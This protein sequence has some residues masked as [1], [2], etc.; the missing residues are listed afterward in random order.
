MTPVDKGKFCG[1]CQK[2]VVDFS[3]MSDRQVAE[4]FKK[5]STG[6]V[7]GR[8]MADQLDRG[9]EIPKK[10]I[11]WLKYFFRFVIPAFLVSIKASAEKRQGK[12]NV[13][14]VTKDTTKRASSQQIVALGM[15]GQVVCSKPLMGDTTVQT[16]AVI[17]EPFKVGQTKTGSNIY[18]GLTGYI[19][20]PVIIRDL[21]S[22][23]A[24]AKT[25]DLSIPAETI[26]LSKEL[27]CRVGGLVINYDEPKQIEGL[28]TDEKGDAVPF[29]SIENGKPGQGVSA[30]E[31]GFFR[32]NKK[33]LNN[34]TGFVVSSAGFESR[35]VI[36]G[37]EK[38]LSG[39]LNVQLKSNGLL[40]EVVLTSFGQ[41]RQGYVIGYSTV[42]GQAILVT[43]K[44]ATNT[45]NVIKLPSEE[46]SLLVY[47]NP[48]SPGATLNISFK[49]PE[50]GYYQL[51]LLNQSGQTVQQKE[52]R[53]DAGAKMVNINILSVAAGSYYL[54]LTDKKSGKRFTEK[55][56][57]TIIF[58]S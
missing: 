25:K 46:N 33:W 37:E 32:I 10:R 27:I 9:I 7:C 26:N 22:P 24:I 48:V 20:G 53:M 28:V 50:E 19:P 47:P 6:S 5:P 21:Q 56:Y 34:K 3:N 17:P 12:I 4:F 55:N 14:T 39:K 52:I 36:K 49:N 8:F 45:N 16:E 31:N 2:Q 23:F 58:E 29:A 42:K 43:D 30:D 15:T 54:V 11:P 51:Q 44:K 1:S 41:I 35:K 38:Y 18:D 40:P 13:N 57:H